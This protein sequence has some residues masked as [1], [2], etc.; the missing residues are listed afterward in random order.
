[1]ARLEERMAVHIRDLVSNEDRAA[2]YF[3][4]EM[5]AA[6]QARYDIRTR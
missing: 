3:K 6:R 4:K 5:E 1:M 2:E